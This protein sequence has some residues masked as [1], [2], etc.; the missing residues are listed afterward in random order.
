[1]PETSMESIGYKMKFNEYFLK[2]IGYLY[3][4]AYVV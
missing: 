2:S 4:T 3:F 1:M